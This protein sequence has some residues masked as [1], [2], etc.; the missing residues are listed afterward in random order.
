MN[1]KNYKGN[2]AFYGHCQSGQYALFCLG[3]GRYNKLINDDS[4]FNRAF[5]SSREVRSDKERIFQG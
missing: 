2:L 4:E 3:F 1:Q 5:A